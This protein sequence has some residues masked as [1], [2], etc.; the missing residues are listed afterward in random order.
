MYILALLPIIPLALAATHT[1]TLGDDGKLAFAPDTVTAA[2][3]DTL[4]FEFYPG[5]HSVAQSTFD[6][7][8]QASPGGI[9]SGF[10]NPP[11]PDEADT[12]FEVTV[13]STDP[14]WL[15]CAQ[16]GHCNAGMAM[17]VNPPYVSLL[18]SFPPSRPLTPPPQQ[19]LR[20]HPRRLQIRRRVRHPQGP[21]HRLR[22]RRQARARKL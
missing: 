3:G 6:A 7:P 12:V 16:V 18:R 20:Q 8:C 22:R 1:I 15:F 4:I 2:V 13:S 19:I 21:D 17:V 14:M 10:F 5:G 9:F 11:G